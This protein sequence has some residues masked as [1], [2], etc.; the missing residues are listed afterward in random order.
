ML[1]VTCWIAFV[2]HLLHSQNLSRKYQQPSSKKGPN[3]LKT[4][5]YTRKKRMYSEL[6]WS[7]SSCTRTEYGEIFPISTYSV[8]ILENEDQNN[9]EYVHFLRSVRYNNFQSIQEI[10]TS[11]KIDNNTNFLLCRL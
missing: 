3:K 4:L 8:R 1:S 2:K 9:S 11:N 7:V 10:R 5:I 6:F